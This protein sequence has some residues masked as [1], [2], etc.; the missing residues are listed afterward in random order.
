MKSYATLKLV[1]CRCAVLCSACVP[2]MP[3]VLK[4]R[5]KVYP[6][7]EAGPSFGSTL[8]PVD[9]RTTQR[10]RAGAAQE[11]RKTSG[12]A[13]NE[14]EDEPAVTT[15]LGSTTCAL[16]T[17]AAA[18]A[19]AAA[20]ASFAQAAAST[21]AAAAAAAS[22]APNEHDTATAIPA[23]RLKLSYLRDR[24]VAPECKV[25]WHG[26]P[27][28]GSSTHSWEKRSDGTWVPKRDVTSAGLRP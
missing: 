26:G 9:S 25:A 27:D 24:K 19:A 28:L 2:K 10:G 16:E 3:A 23:K 13:A 12:P 17:A 20:A 7:G 8:Y 15:T 1:L 5:T 6:T 11:L 21:A 14:E 18:L 4:R 22:S